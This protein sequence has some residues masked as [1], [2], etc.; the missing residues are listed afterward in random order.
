MTAD[1]AAFQGSVPVGVSSCLLGEEVRHDGGHKRHAIVIDVLGPAVEWIPVCPEFEMGLGVPRE[2]LRL[3]RDRRRTRL[4]AIE[5]RAD[6]AETIRRW[7]AERLK[8]LEARQI[9]GYVLKSR[10]PSCGLQGVPVYDKAGNRTKTGRGLFAAALCRRFPNLPVEEETA[11]TDRASAERFL[12]RARAYS[13]LRELFRPR[14]KAGDVVAWQE[15]SEGWLRRR[16][17]ALA[18]ELAR[19]TAT[20]DQLSRRRFRHDYETLFMQAVSGALQPLG[21]PVSSRRPTRRPARQ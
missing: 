8:G 21:A 2:P 16:S 20:P 19:L 18:G 12:E 13:Q 3:E 1:N 5:T 15:R 14:W 6:H 9:S 7:S 4:V 17:P 10:S 11:F